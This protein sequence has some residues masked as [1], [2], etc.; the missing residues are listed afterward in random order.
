M[1]ELALGNKYAISRKSHE[2]DSVGHP[3]Y[4]QR[5]VE[6]QAEAFGR[7]RR[8]Q[9]CNNHCGH[10]QGRNNG[11]DVG[12]AMT[13][14]IYRRSPQGKGRQ[15]LVG[16]CKVAPQH[17]EVEQHQSERTGKYRQRYQYAFQ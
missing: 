15:Q 17:V 5:V 8:K 10:K 12:T 3:G 14:K 16:P 7:W 1:Y 13:G 2:A 4:Y 6:T 11:Y 9:I